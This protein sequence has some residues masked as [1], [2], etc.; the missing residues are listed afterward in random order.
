MRQCRSGHKSVMSSCNYG[1]WAKTITSPSS[2]TSSLYDIPMGNSNAVYLLTAAITAAMME[3]GAKRQVP[4]IILMCGDMS[5]VR[6]LCHKMSN[7]KSMGTYFPPVGVLA[8][9]CVSDRSLFGF[10]AKRGQLCCIISPP[11]F[12]SA[13][14]PCSEVCVGEIG[15]LSSHPE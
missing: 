9:H 14:A 10:L 11:C 5:S 12:S 13:I 15:N 4:S 8:D 7:T 3:I 2:T 1:T 6:L